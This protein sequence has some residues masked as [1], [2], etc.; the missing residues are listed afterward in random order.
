[1]LSYASVLWTFMKQCCINCYP[2]WRYVP[3]V[4]KLLGSIFVNGM[5]WFR[6]RQ[7]WYVDTQPK[8]RSMMTCKNAAAGWRC[9]RLNEE[10]IGIFTHESINNVGSIGFISSEWKSG[11]ESWW[12]IWAAELHWDHSRWMAV[13]INFVNLLSVLSRNWICNFMA[14]RNEKAENERLYLIASGRVFRVKSE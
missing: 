3:L 8:T 13:L 9:Y 11:H 5:E 2:V 10:R 12:M 7:I 4:T 1:M 6:P 14:L